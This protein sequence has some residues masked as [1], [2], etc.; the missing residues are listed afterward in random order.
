MRGDVPQKIMKKFDL[1]FTVPA[2]KIFNAITEQKIYPKQWKVEYGVP[3]PK[4]PFPESEDQIRVLSKT[5]FLSKIYESFVV[6]WL[7]GYIRPY[8]DPGQFGGLPYK[9]IAFHP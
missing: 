7:L 3:I 6:D 8:L 9:I 2:T 5:A 1:E 4:T